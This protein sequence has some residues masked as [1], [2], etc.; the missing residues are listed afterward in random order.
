[1]S[2]TEQLKQFGIPSEDTINDVIKDCIEMGQLK[3]E[4]DIEKFTIA[5]KGPFPVHQFHML[6]RQYGLAQSEMRRMLLDKDEIERNIQE[7]QDI[8]PKWFDEAT[9]RWKFKDIEIKRLQN[10][11]DMLHITVV[12]KIASCA[13]FE[14]CRL[15]FH[16]LYGDKLINENYQA[17][18][19][20][21][22]KWHLLNL[23]KEEASER[24]TGIKQGTWMI[25][26]Q[27]DA[28]A[29][30]TPDYKLNLLENG[31]L[32]LNT[33]NKALPEK[34]QVHAIRR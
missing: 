14:K 5:S 29:L 16:E 9:N 31:G 18:E 34:D 23:A 4:F 27:C 11:L 17:E 26:A 6:M 20:E 28:P 22:I 12:N 21:A 24:L 7:L 10:D 30:L 19:P 3:S 2:L 33:L 8:I 15:K 1:M 25:A 32:D 13:Y